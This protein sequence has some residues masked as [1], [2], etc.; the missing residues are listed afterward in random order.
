MLQV[1]N[2]AVHIGDFL[3]LTITVTDSPVSKENDPK[4]R[5]RPQ[6]PHSCRPIEGWGPASRSPSPDS[7]LVLSRG[8]TSQ[9]RPTRVVSSFNDPNDV[10]K[11]RGSPRQRRETDAGLVKVKT[12]S[13]YD[14]SALHAVGEPRAISAP[15]TT[16]LNRKMAWGTL[17]GHRPTMMPRIH[18]AMDKGL[19]TIN[20]SLRGTR[21]LTLQNR[22]IFDFGNFAALSGRVSSRMYAGAR[23]MLSQLTSDDEGD[24]VEHYRSR[25]DED[26]NRDRGN[27]DDFN[28]NGNEND[29]GLDLEQQVQGSLDE[30]TAKLSNHQP[31]APD[32]RP[33]RRRQGREDLAIGK[34]AQLQGTLARHGRWDSAAKDLHRKLVFKVK[35]RDL[36][37]ALLQRHQTN[38]SLDKGSTRETEA[39]IRELGEDIS[40]LH[41]RLFDYAFR[42]NGE[43]K[44]I[45][46]DEERV[47]LERY[48]ILANFQN[49]YVLRDEYVIQRGPIARTP[50]AQRDHNTRRLQ[51][52]RRARTTARARAQSRAAASANDEGNS[53]S[54]AMTSLQRSP[55]AVDTEREI[56]AV[57]RTLAMGSSSNQSA[58]SEDSAAEEYSAD[59]QLPALHAGSNAEGLGEP[60]CTGHPDQ[61]T[62]GDNQED[63]S[64]LDDKEVDNKQEAT[65]GTFA[66]HGQLPS[67]RRVSNLSGAE[68]VPDDTFQ[69]TENH[70]E[71]PPL[72]PGEEEAML[73]MFPPLTRVPTRGREHNTTSLDDVPYESHERTDMEQYGNDVDY[74]TTGDRPSLPHIVVSDADRILDPLAGAGT[75]HEVALQAP[76]G[77]TIAGH[78]ARDILSRRARMMER[79]QARNRTMMPG[80]DLTI[81]APEID[82][83]PAASSQVGSDTTQATIIDGFQRPE[84]NGSVVRQEV[85]SE[86]ESARM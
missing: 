73:D 75:D 68:Q 15:P 5:G 25:E 51:A 28:G 18:Q 10:G 58:D 78:I 54:T 29:A 33:R 71:E 83:R 79:H 1:M 52:S 40:C 59:T 45:P 47:E 32:V 67:R 21:R 61:A 48:L 77:A 6:S 86:G 20:E 11:R 39:K 65:S 44:R 37:L 46:S 72:D 82:E 14:A 41:S 69:P 76:S 27:S 63:K 23:E 62:S 49:S 56:Q 36:H 8:P 43:R 30:A 26:E 84:Q 70:A 60:E 38:W 4:K 64:Q 74:N 42:E 19:Q 53:D 9:K 24:C 13:A 57:Y 55:D 7:G 3:E 34:L 80:D 81:G 17:V 31:T 35:Q 66:F 12:S 22:Q 50:E 85:I 2:R 16:K